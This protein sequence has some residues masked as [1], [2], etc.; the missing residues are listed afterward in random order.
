MFDRGTGYVWHPDRA[1][2]AG[3]NV[4]QADVACFLQLEIGGLDRGGPLLD[5]LRNRCLEFLRR[6]SDRIYAVVFKRAK[7]LLVL[8]SGLHLLDENL[9]DRIRRPGGRDQPVPGLRPETLEAA[10]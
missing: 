3:S 8:E 9:D 4:R 5:V 10:F 2:A 6:R 7:N 1:E